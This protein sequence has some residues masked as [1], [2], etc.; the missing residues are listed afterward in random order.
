ML[1]EHS[2]YMPP[3]S[4]EFEM[5]FREDPNRRVFWLDDPAGL[6]VTEDQARAY[7]TIMDRDVYSGAFHSPIRRLLTE[8]ACAF[9][10]H[11]EGTVSFVDLGPGY[12][13]KSL[14]LIGELVERRKLRHYIAVD[15]NSYFLRIAVDAVSRFAPGVPAVGVQEGFAHLS[16]ALD[17]DFPR[18][19][20]E[21]RL[22]VLG[23][24]FLNFRPR[25]ILP[26][27]SNLVGSNDVL[28]LAT[29]LADGLSVS[30]MM[31]PYQ[32]PSVQRFAAS[33][34]SM[35]G[36]DLGDLEFDLRFNRIRLE[37]GFCLRRSVMT[38]TGQRLGSGTRIVTAVSY[39]Y[40][41]RLLRIAMQRFFARVEEV[42]D[43]GGTVL[44]LRSSAGRR[45]F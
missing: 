44:V 9:L 45:A 34:L 12:P 41:A 24:T 25:V 6:Y 21:S 37:V 10:P 33:P 26:I 35:L 13:D 40:P 15:V 23:L 8:Q 11:G 27:L 22:F 39:R 42:T 28:I 5:Q 7:L 20:K 18:Q 19:R 29:Q 30:E 1:A 38:A 2:L 4:R 3:I 36:L 14:G 31:A 43:D 16:K 17:R 32:D